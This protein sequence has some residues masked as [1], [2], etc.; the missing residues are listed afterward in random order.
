MK[1]LRSSLFVGLVLAGAAGAVSCG[2]ENSGSGSPEAPFNGV[3]GTY[4]NTYIWG[5]SEATAPP[6]E[7]ISVAALVPQPSGGYTTIEGSFYEDG[8]F[9]IPGVPPGSYLLKI[10]SDGAAPYFYWTKERVIEVG[11]LYANR[12]DTRPVTISP[13]S[14]VFEV[15]GMSPWQ[16]TDVIEILS[17]G[18]GAF[19]LPFFELT[20]GVTSLEGASFD[21]FEMFPGNLIDGSKGDL[22]YVTQ[23]V[24]RDAGGAPYT[25]I[26]KVFTPPPFSMQDGQPTTLT[27][28]F[29][30]VPQKTLS[31]DW[32][33]SAFG[34][35]AKD[36]HPSAALFDS[37]F[38]LV[39][40]YGGTSRI[41]ATIPPALLSF[42]GDSE[43]VTD[44]AGELSYGNPFPSAWGLVATASASFSLSVMLPGADASKLLTGEVYCSTLL[45]DKSSLTLLPGLGPVEDILVNGKP[46]ADWLTGAGLAPT[47]SWSPPA[48][49]TAAR[50]RVVL[51]RLD[52][53]APNAGTSFV[54][55][56]STA[57]T[58][59][60]L[61]E[62]LLG[63]GNYY[64]IRV[65]A[66]EAPLNLTD[67]DAPD[68]YGCGSVAFTHVF[69]P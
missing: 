49:G 57:E 31:V 17:Q 3:K 62:G 58:S 9:E 61:P 18:A 39:A 1:N 5:V 8:T 34:A 67:R 27:G 52:P 22:L 6:I 43:T 32:K 40:E 16:E 23:L 36:V 2:S 38:S 37:S 63:A 13:T 7:G 56:F 53:N 24:T 59:I 50:Y 35:L 19:G 28:S 25:S 60:A 44:F 48:M 54:G 33:R 47:V 14:M 20:P 10:Q 11:Y 15:G 68:T 26:G 46:T 41:T 4:L 55:S 30:D 12:P 21:A 65:F 45:G 69:E 29:S 42:S 51:R 66:D 64:Y